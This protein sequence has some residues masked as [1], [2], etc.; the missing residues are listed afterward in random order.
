MS[1]IL[2]YVH[3]D[4]LF[5]RMHPG[6]KIFLIIVVGLIT[7]L[8]LDIALLCLIL[9]A[10]LGMALAG[11]VLREVLQQM[12][13]ILAMSVI[14]ILITLI[15]MPDGQVLGYLLPGGYLPVTTGA[16]YAGILLTLRFA[17]LIISFQVFVITTQ[18]RDL[19]NT[20]EKIG[21]PSDYNLMFLIALRFIPTLQIEARKIHEAQLARGYY[22]GRGFIG[23]IKSVAPVL[24]PLVSNA[25]SRAT[26]LGLTIDMRGLR[27]RART[28][29][30]EERLN[31][32]DKAVIGILGMVLITFLAATIL[33]FF[34]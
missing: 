7:I 31:L 5:H 2:Q 12:A 21:V 15:T 27:T 32:L 28:P 4:G 23:R 6:T 1:E 34:F 3:K 26:V 24:I 10:V 9:L 29:F 25:L 19:V 20:L 16:L 8:T 13:L 18:P 14:F 30:R 11:R 33:P 22:P 17:I